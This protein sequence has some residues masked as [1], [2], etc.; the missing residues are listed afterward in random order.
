MIVRTGGRRSDCRPGR[1]PGRVELNDTPTAADSAKAA[2]VPAGDQTNGQ[3][4]RQARNRDAPMPTADA[5]ESAAEREKRDRLDQ[6]L[7]EDVRAAERRSPAGGRSRGC[8][9]ATETSMMLTTPI[10]PTR[11]ES[12]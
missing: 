5:D 9:R 8:A 12:T 4:A 11:S 2:A 6:E 1:P 10:P 7:R 3:C